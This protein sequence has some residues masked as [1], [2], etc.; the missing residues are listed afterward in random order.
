MKRNIQ[1]WDVSDFPYFYRLIFQTFYRFL[2]KRE[3]DETV[4]FRNFRKSF[5]NKWSPRFYGILALYFQTAKT[6]E[7]ND[8]AHEARCNEVNVSPKRT[9]GSDNQNE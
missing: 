3:I 2:A 4:N 7:V 5:T 1:L 9:Y 8:K 6:K